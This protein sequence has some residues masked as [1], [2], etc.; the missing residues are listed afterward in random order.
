MSF[1][2]FKYYMREHYD[3][4]LSIKRS[5]EVKQPTSTLPGQDSVQFI[6]LNVDNW[7]PAG[8]GKFDG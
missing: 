6:A 8:L 3:M 2:S 1:A 5:G 7:R 4:F